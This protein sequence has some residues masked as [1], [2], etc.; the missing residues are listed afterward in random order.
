MGT[1]SAF[2][3]GGENGDEADNGAGAG[4]AGGTGILGVGVGENGLAGTESVATG[5]VIGVGF[6]KNG[7]WRLSVIEHDTKYS[8]W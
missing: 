2:T 5:G 6:C 3:T 4:F 7:G 1:G 8:Q